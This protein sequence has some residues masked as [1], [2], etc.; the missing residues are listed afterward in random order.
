MPVSNI[1]CRFT[2]GQLKARALRRIALVLQETAE[3]GRVPHSRFFE[4]LIPDPWITVGTSTNGPGWR[5]HVV[6]CAYLARECMRKFIDG[7]ASEE[8]VSLL[9][10]HLKIVNISIDERNHLD[11]TLGYKNR[12]PEEW[13]FGVGD[14][15]AR[16]HAAGIKLLETPA[17]SSGEE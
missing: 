7:T 14:P 13:V 16:I 4:T 2:D 11:F 9:G 17:I 12:M 5:E 10:S 3:E 15:F 1:I 6:P 8:V